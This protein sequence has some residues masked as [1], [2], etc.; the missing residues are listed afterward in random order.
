MEISWV[1]ETSPTKINK[2]RMPIP[3]KARE[4]IE[5]TL[6]GRAHG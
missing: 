4:I 2:K 3:P 1:Y 5:N 6:K